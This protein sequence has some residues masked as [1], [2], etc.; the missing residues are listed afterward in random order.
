[1][2]ELGGK[3]ADE[4]IRPATYAWTAALAALLGFAAVYVTHTPRD[5]GAVQ[6]SSPTA[7]APAP[8]AAAKPA[9][10]MAGFVRRAAPEPMGD[11]EFQTGDGRQIRLSDFKGRTVLLNL[12][13]TWCAPC[14]K[15]MPSLDRLQKELGSD[16]FEVVA[17]AVDRGGADGARKFLDETK[18]ESLKLYVDPTAKTGTAL[19]AVGMPT[20]IL[21]DKDG[22]EIGRLAGPAEWDH[23][24]AKR[25]IEAELR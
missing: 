2:S 7:Q 3:Q 25:L 9:G 16:K 24:E 21:I 10:T 19:R 20:T 6:P 18:V 12:W 14:R 5:N 1:M 8:A 15:E 22:R 13:A 17:L 23:P 11:V 4:R